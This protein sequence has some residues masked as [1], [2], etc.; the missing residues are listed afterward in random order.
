MGCA[1]AGDSRSVYS[2]NSGKAIA[3]SY[4]HKPDDEPEETRIMKAGGYVSGGRVDGDLA[5]SRGFG[6]FRFKACPQL[7]PHDQRVS[8]I[9]DIMVQNRND[10]E[11]EFIILACD[12]IWDVA[13]NQECVQMVTDIF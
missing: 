5:V 7:E 12:G 1:N 8:P 2:K 13:T 3:L 10:E 4:D 9:P 6:D 11:D